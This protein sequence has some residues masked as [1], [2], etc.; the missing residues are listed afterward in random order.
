MRAARRIL[1]TSSSC[2]HEV[3]E[4]LQAVFVSELLA[5]SRWLWL[6]SP[7]LS[8]IEIIDNR[9]GSFNALEPLWGRRGIRL[10]EVLGRILGYGIT[11]LVVATR[12]DA[13]N[14]K[15]LRTLRATVEGQ[16]ARGQLR[17]LDYRQHLHVKGVLGDDFFI[18]G[19]MNITYFGIELL[20][21]SV[22]FETEPNDIAGA[23]IL[24]M[25]NFGGGTDSG[26]S[27]DQGGRA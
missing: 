24:F 5:P 3:R 20:E 15:F 4:L 9:T 8:D 14:Q 21:E 26:S 25:E 16:G 18:S 17:I 7:W 22:L 27:V 23:R 12:P 11:N 13:H 10:S 2:Q 6:V 19:S 1:K